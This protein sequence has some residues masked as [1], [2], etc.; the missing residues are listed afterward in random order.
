MAFCEGGRS[1]GLDQRPATGLPMTYTTGGQFGCPIHLDADGTLDV[2][3]RASVF[4]TTSH[5]NHSGEQ[6]ACRLRRPDGGA[7]DNH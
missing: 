6:P 3:F 5:R 1:P 7:N 2:D 4:S